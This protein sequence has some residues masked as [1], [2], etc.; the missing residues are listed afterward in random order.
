MAKKRRKYTVEELWNPQIDTSYDACAYARQSTKDQV[1]ENIQSRISQ[2]VGILI[3]AKGLGFKDDG[4]TGAVHLFVENQVVDEDGNVQIKNASGTWPIDKRPGLKAI[5]DLIEEDKIKLV[6]VEFVDRLFRDEDRIDSNIFIKACREHD[7][8]VYITSKKMTY[9]FANPQMADMFRQ[10]VAFAAAYIEHHVRGVMIRRRDMAVQ[11]GRWGGGYIP[12]GFIVCREKGEKYNRYLPYPPHV[13]IIKELAQEFIELGC[14]I[15]LL[16]RKHQDGVFFPDFGPEVTFIGPRRATKVNGGYLVKSRSGIR[17]L[18]ANPANDGTMEY[19]ESIFVKNIHE[20]ILDPESY[21]LI[22]TKLNPHGADSKKRR[23]YQKDSAVTRVGTLKKLIET[24][25]HHS[26]AYL[27]VGPQYYY[28]IYKPGIIKDEMVCLPAPYFEGL[29]EGRLLTKVQ[30]YDLGNFEEELKERKKEKVTR[31]AKIQQRIEVIEEELDAL[32]SNL[33]TVQLPAFVERIEKRGKKLEEEKLNLQEQH[34]YLGVS[35][36]EDGDS[37]EA[38]LSKL[39][40]DTFSKKPANIRR[41]LLELLIKRICIERM[42]GKFFMVTVEWKVPEW[43]A[44]YVYIDRSR[45]NSKKWTKEEIA[46]L[47]ELYPTSSETEILKAIP[48]RDWFSVRRQALKFGV[49]RTVKRQ[50]VLNF[51]A[52]M[53]WSDLQFLERIGHTVDNVP[54]E[55]WNDVSGLKVSSFIVLLPSNL[56][57]ACKPSIS[58]A[59]VLKT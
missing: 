56:G 23:Y 1:I 50:K 54:I 15:G 41:G 12:L 21:N 53:S 36:K 16:Y 22:N 59:T 58:C 11:S 20:R 27:R 26:C 32:A 9:N 31:M 39:S 24:D 29:I 3:E 35:L 55:K 28:R 37:I 48:K 4:S 44:E 30:S 34:K 5:I 43:G 18:L 45:E 19:G 2:T 49:K 38:E 33:G 57:A 25:E 46:A 10:E 6:I 47:K 51:D 8:F 13:Q 42:S 14:D 52:S 17:S 7:C 40:P